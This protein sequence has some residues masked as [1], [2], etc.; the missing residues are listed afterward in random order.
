MMRD[1]YDEVRR[2]D[3]PWG[4]PGDIDPWAD[5]LTTVPVK[6]SAGV[7][8]AKSLPASMQHS[9]DPRRTDLEKP[10]PAS[11]KPSNAPPVP[12][13]L[14]PRLSS[15]SCN[16]LPKAAPP[17]SMR[18]SGEHTRSSNQLSTALEP[19]GSDTSQV[20]IVSWQTGS[21]EEHSLGGSRRTAKK[22]TKEQSGKIPN[23]SG[24]PKEVIKSA[25]LM[26]RLSNPTLWEPVRTSPGD[27]PW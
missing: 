9:A 13:T 8:D 10:D 16:S 26:Q 17:Q 5:T 23:K 19:A 2:R 25:E 7:D 4:K 21:T 14:E 20:K 24:I 22:L 11:I 12:K 1:L 27:E 15:Q 18:Q 6:G 3:E